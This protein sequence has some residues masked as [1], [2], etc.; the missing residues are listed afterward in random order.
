M[1]LQYEIYLNEEK[2]YECDDREKAHGYIR[3]NHNDL[4]PFL[5]YEPLGAGSIEC[6]TNGMMDIKIVRL[7][8][9]KI[10]INKLLEKHNHIEE[11]EREIPKEV[12]V[13]KATPL[14]PMR[15]RIKS[16]N[17]MDKAGEGKRKKDK[18]GNLWIS[19]KN[20]K[21]EYKWT[22]YYEENYENTNRRKSPKQPAKNFDEGTVKKGLDGKFWMVRILSNGAKK[23]FRK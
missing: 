7:K 23:W 21:G 11:R 12:N 18:E 1:L 17:R 20:K 8:K 9:G 16:N 10:D 22:R 5:E 2:V 3:K 15:T 4:I 6:W 19:K 13:E 14:T